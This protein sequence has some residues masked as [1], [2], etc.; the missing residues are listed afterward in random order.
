MYQ[1]MFVQLLLHPIKI[2]YG[3]RKNGKEGREK[4]GYKNT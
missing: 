1:H 2:K 3:P 4:T